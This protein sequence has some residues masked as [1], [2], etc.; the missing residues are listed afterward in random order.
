MAMQNGWRTEEVDPPESGF[1]IRASH[2]VAE[3]R[4]NSRIL[5]RV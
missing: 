2:A 5:R 4:E 3:T 1:M